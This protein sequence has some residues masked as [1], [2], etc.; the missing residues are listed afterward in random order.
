MSPSAAP[1]AVRATRTVN[2]PAGASSV[3]LNVNEAVAPST[4]GVS[5]A[6]TRTAG[7]SSSVMVSVTSAGPLTPTSLSAVPDTLT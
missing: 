7:T 1:D 2:P 4:I 3:E 6:T 5:S